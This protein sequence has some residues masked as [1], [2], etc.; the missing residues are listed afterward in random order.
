MIYVIFN[1][2]D[3]YGPDFT[4]HITTDL[5]AAKALV[6][7]WAVVPGY[8]GDRIVLNWTERK[9]TWRAHAFDD[10]QPPQPTWEYGQWLIVGVEPS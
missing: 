8:G 6:E 10:D 4:G 5:D 2:G 1:D 9:T 3:Y 7:K